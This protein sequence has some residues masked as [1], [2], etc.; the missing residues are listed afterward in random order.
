MREDAGEHRPRSRPDVRRDHQRVHGALGAS[1]R[2]RWRIESGLR[3][4]QIIISCKTSR[5]RDLIAVYRAL[6]RADRSAAAPRAHRSRHGHQGAGLVGGGDGR[7]AQRRHRRHDPRLADA[8]ARRRSPRRGLRRV[9]AAAGARPA[10]RSR[11]ASPPARAAAA[12]RARTFQELAERMQDYIREQMPDVEDALRRRR[13]DDARG[14]GLRRQ[15]PGRIEGGQH[16]HQPARHRRGAELPGLHRRRARDDAA[17][18]LRRARRRVPASGRRLRRARRTRGKPDRST[19]PTALPCARR[20]PPRLGLLRLPSAAARSDARRPRRA[21]TASS[22]C[23][24]AAASRCASRRRRWSSGSAA[25]AAAT[26]GR[27]AAS[28]WSSRR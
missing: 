13:D 27:A 22:C 5:P 10:R 20:A 18:H 19:S 25:G 26:H 15:R 9:R 12:R 11:R 21:A 1:S 23:R 6:A 4:D 24:P 2:P 28:R 16:R 17:R 3:K 7:A 8:A 14:D